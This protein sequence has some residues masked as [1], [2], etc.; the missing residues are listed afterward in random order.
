[1]MEPGH[2]VIS[3]GSSGIGL[4]LARRLVEAGW[5][6]TILARDP[7]RLSAA[8]AELSALRGNPRQRVRCDAVDVADNDAVVRVVAAAVATFG[9]PSLVVA[10][11]GMVPPGK[12]DDLPLAAFRAAIEVNYFGTLHLVRAAL[13]AMRQAGG[14]RIV[15]IASGAALLGL[16]GFT[17]YA[18]SKFAV[19]GLAEALRGELAPDR[20]VVSIVYPPDTDTPQLEEENKTKPEETKLMTAIAKTW[21]ADAVADCMLRGINRGAFAITPGATITMMHRMPGLLVPLLHRYCDRL[22]DG[23]RRK[24]AAAAG[25]LRQGA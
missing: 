10:S 20:I 6:L 8:E 3:G 13:P 16:Y 7:A 17:A 24:R 12:F 4:A 21:T 2:A 23:V 5:D 15:M 25:A 1:M 9:S 11:A 19:R 18:P 22:A 14:G